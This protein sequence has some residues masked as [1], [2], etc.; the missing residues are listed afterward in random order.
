M[1][2]EFIAPSSDRIRR[3]D[4]DPR[5]TRTRDHGSMIHE[6][7]RVPALPAEGTVV[8]RSPAA[9]AWAGVALPLA[10][11]RRAGTGFRTPANAQTGPRMPLRQFHARGRGPNFAQHG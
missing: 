3:S 2:S 10:C 8:P 6:P 9:R 11:P 4:A 7:R 5:T 1:M